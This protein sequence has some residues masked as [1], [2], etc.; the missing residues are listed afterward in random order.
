VLSRITAALSPETRTG[1]GDAA[2]VCCLD[3]LLD[4]AVVAATGDLS[5]VYGA[6][7]LLEHAPAVGLAAG[8]RRAAED[9][10]ATRRISSRYGDL[11]LDALG[12]TV[13][14]AAESVRGG[15]GVLRVPYPS[16]QSYFA[17][18]YNEPRLHDLTGSFLSHDF[19]HVFR[20][21]VAR[22]ISDFVGTEALPTVSSSALLQDRIAH[23]CQTTARAIDLSDTEQIIREALG[24]TEAAKRH[25]I[26]HGVFGEA[27]A[28]GLNALSAGD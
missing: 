23:T 18:F 15:G 2:V 3:H 17:D 14:D 24:Q 12:A 28:L 6:A 7:T 8:L 11:A 13:L 5:A 10:I 26:L 21:F 25:H 22:D 1:L 27:V 4:G 20:Y 19:D 9:D 16:L